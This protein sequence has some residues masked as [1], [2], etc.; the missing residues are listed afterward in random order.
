MIKIGLQRSEQ[1]INTPPPHILIYSTISK[2][3]LQLNLSIYLH[4]DIA[5]PDQCLNWPMY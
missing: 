2:D 1:C 3:K 5:S 4:F